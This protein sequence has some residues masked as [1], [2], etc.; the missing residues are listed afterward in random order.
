MF[1]VHCGKPISDNA[2]FCRFCGGSCT[3]G[4][5]E[6]IK[7][8]SINASNHN[9]AQTT[10]N[11][12]LSGRC[13]VPVADTT[14]PP[15]S[16]MAAHYEKTEEMPI[17]PPVPILELSPKKKSRKGLWIS[18]CAVGAVLVSVLIFFLVN[19]GIFGSG[20][21]NEQSPIEPKDGECY[22]VGH[23]SYFD[24][25]DM[26]FSFILS[27]DKSYIYGITIKLTNLSGSVTVGSTTTSVKVASAVERFTGKYPL[28]KT[29]VIGSSSLGEITFTGKTAWVELDYTYAFTS[30]SGGKVEIEFGKSYFELETENDTGNDPTGTEDSQPSGDNTETVFD[31]EKL[32][33]WS[34]AAIKSRCGV[35]SIDYF[36]PS[37]AVPMYY[38]VSAD[39]VIDPVTGLESEGGYNK[40]RARH[41]PISTET[42]LGVSGNLKNGGLILTNDPNKATFA[43]VL[44]YSYSNNIGSFRFGDDGSVVP[45]YHAT[46]DAE[47]VN[48]VT[49]ERI[50]CKRQNG[51]ATY[52]GES[53]Y[54][55]MLNAAKGKQ[56]YG[57]TIPLDAEDFEGYWSFVKK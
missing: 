19:P 9:E 20:S 42:M 50:S 32:K 7:S 17:P 3:G 23:A 31:T 57:G 18:L 38:I 54:K 22:Y 47:L 30:A 16:D 14:P 21:G 11:A 8:D 5:G 39:V 2:A 46:L 51:Y 1:C 41:L 40:S 4:D 33:N 49:G 13:A 12:Q 29:I 35:S 6:A 34:N 48:L 10:D 15:E 28:D 52:A 24:I 27:A 36:V 45:Q 25:D 37:S 55:S 43:L 53:V 44:H 26:E 56:F